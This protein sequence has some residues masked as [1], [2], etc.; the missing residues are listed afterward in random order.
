MKRFAILAIHHVYAEAIYDGKKKFE[1]RKCSIKTKRIYIYETSPIKLITGI[2]E[3]GEPIEL[4]IDDI[5]TN[6]L[7]ET[8]LTP[9]LIDSYAKGRK[10]LWLW[11]IENVARTMPTKYN[12]P[13]IQMF[14]YVE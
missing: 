13:T 7:K 5:K 6:Y 1:V 12:G 2:I 11:P 8:G 10:T 9:E 4:P 3:I 14:K